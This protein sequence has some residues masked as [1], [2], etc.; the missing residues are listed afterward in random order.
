MF[1]SLSGMYLF[2]QLKLNNW[3]I[4]K[5]CILESI[6]DKFMSNRWM[7]FLILINIEWFFF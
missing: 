2:V 4:I 6:I 5:R 3:Y 1:L 7:V